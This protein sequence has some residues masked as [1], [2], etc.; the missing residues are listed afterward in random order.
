MDHLKHFLASPN[1]IGTVPDR[2][3]VHDAVPQPADAFKNLPQ[4]ARVAFGRRSMGE[5]PFERMPAPEPASGPEML[6]VE[7]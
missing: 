7:K 5:D 6:R 4:V 2:F 1:Q 3:V